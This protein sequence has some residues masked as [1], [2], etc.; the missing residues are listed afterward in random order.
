[1]ALIKDI[2]VTNYET[3]SESVVI[4]DPNG[5]YTLGSLI[6]SVKMHDMFLGTGFTI[7]QG[8]TT[9]IE[10]RDFALTQSEEDILMTEDYG[11][12][13]YSSFKSYRLSGTVTVSYR[14]VATYDRAGLILRHESR[15]NN[16]DALIDA[17]EAVNVN[18]DNAISDLASDLG[19]HK[20]NNVIHVSTYDRARW[21]GRTQ[22][23]IADNITARDALTGMKVGDICNVIVGA[24][25]DGKS[26]KYI[27]SST[28]WQEITDTDLNPDVMRMTNRT[29]APSATAG[30]FSLFAIGDFLFGITSAG[31]IKRFLSRLDTSSFV[32]G[33]P[34]VAREDGTVETAEWQGSG[35]GTGN[36]TGPSTSVVDEIAT[37]NNTTGTLIKSS[38]K[39]IGNASGNVPL[40]NGVESVA[41]VSAY[42]MRLKRMPSVVSGNIIGI[43]WDRG[44]GTAF[45]YNASGGGVGGLPSG[46]ATYGNV[47]VYG[48]TSDSLRLILR[49]A[50][51]LTTWT[52]HVTSA[53]NGEW[54][55]IRNLSGGAGE[56]QRLY[57]G[58]AWVISRMP[59]GMI[60]VA[61]GIQSSGSVV[62]ANSS[63]TITLP[64]SV[65]SHMPNIVVA[66]SSSQTSML[67]GISGLTQVTI[68][69]N[70][71]YEAAAHF[72][73]IGY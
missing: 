65:F 45:Y 29:A 4:T 21:D 63:L 38:G 26:E 40:S 64:V 55:K 6:E 42:S 20:A 17:V 34:L 2:D 32:A 5:S 50:T 70:S 68:T 1:M 58:G 37:F 67:G 7:T 41:L 69:N 14:Q 18:Q 24:N 19:V 52:V 61:Y 60:I 43:A 22:T 49:D 11:V 23:F 30:R 10:G 48:T 36:V 16:H 56:S 57:T 39:K 25:E 72:T 31:A 59:D 66:N 8:A 47:E 15:L 33:K 73:L 9:Y 44:A 46:A 35:G 54:V 12:P 62:P 3:K 51:S 71:A 13:L 27:Y 28:G 53:G